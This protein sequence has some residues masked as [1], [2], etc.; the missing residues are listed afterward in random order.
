MN[1]LISS[2][3]SHN[4]IKKHTRLF[5][6]LSVAAMISSMGV[7][8]FLPNSSNQNLVYADS[9]FARST[10]SKT[11]SGLVAQDSLTNDSS[12]NTNYWTLGGDAVAMNAPHSYSEDSGGLH[13]G[14]QAASSGQWAGF[15]AMTPK[16]LPS[17]TMQRL[18]SHSRQ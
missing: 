11:N 10:F 18:A 6:I 16:P 7:I 4:M 8:S 1:I 13:I 14:V 2:Y 5:S 9:Q 3:E 12:V 17:Y 15:Y